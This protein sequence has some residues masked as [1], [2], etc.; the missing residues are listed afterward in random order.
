MTAYAPDRRPAR[1]RAVSPAWQLAYRAFGKI[2]RLSDPDLQAEFE[3]HDHCL[4]EIA[5]ER[6]RDWLASLP[7]AERGRQERFDR[8]RKAAT[9]EAA[10][11]RL[12]DRRDRERLEQHRRDAE[13]DRVIAR[14]RRL[15]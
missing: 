13:H 2:R 5:A 11:A 12:R 4:A 3:A 1:R 7:P 14:L 6:H 10:V 9:V 8:L 15:R